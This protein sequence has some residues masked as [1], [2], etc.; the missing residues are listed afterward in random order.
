MAK[1]IGVQPS[2]EIPVATRTTEVQIAT[3]NQS[4]FLVNY[5]PGAMDVFINGMLE[6]ESSY[7]ATTGDDVIFNTPLYEN[8]KVVFVKYSAVRQV[9]N[10]QTNNVISRDPSTTDA[11]NLGFDIGSRW[12]NILTN[13]EFVCVDATPGAAVWVNTTKASTTFL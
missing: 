5:T 13:E 9:F 2:V 3:S 6:L 7:D 10:A 11:S 12:T 4:M 8:D 1:Y